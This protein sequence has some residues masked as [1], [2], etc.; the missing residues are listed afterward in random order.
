MAALAA[1]L[2]LAVERHCRQS[3]LV[4]WRRRSVPSRFC[5]RRAC[6]TWFPADS[7]GMIRKIRQI[8][9]FHTLDS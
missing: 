2:A 4:L 8:L 1:A 6:Q 5:C 9:Q 7:A 3:S